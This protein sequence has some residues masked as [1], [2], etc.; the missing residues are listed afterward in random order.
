MISVSAQT[1]P[2]S[3]FSIRFRS[4]TRNYYQGAHAIIV[5]YDITSQSSFHDVREWVESVKETVGLSLPIL[6]LGNKLDVTHDREVQKSIAEDMAEV[7]KA[8]FVEVSAKSGENVAN[9]FSQLLK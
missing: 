5:M 7:Y 8:S 3:Y 2:K 6:L 9:S 4:I 1:D